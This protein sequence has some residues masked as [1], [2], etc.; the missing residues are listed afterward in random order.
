MT[1]FTLDS[2]KILDGYVASA[3]VDADSGMLMAGHSQGDIDL[4]LAAAGNA[5]VVPPSAGLPTRCVSKV[6]S[7]TS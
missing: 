7:K 1:Q 2:L 4:D 3:L 5:E 6:R